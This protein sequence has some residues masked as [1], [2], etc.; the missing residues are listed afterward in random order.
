MA[1]SIEFNGN[2]YP[3]QNIS[4]KGWGRNL[5][6]ATYELQKCLFHDSSSSNY[7]SREA[8][9]IDELIFYYVSPNEIF[10]LPTKLSKIILENL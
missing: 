7:V 1:G 2:S 8:E 4:V 5:T 3:I 9:L 6:I 10:L